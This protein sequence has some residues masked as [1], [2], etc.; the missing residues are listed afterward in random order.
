MRILLVITGLGVGGAERL[1]TALADHYG[2]LGHEVALAYFHGEVELEPSNDRVRL[3]NLQ[4]TRTPL[5]VISAAWRLR[6]LILE[7]R[8]DV[9]NTHLV[10]A[11]I[12]SRVL[13]LI[14]PIPKLVTSA[15]NTFEGGQLRMLGYRLTNCLANA[16][17]NVSQEAVEAFE[18][19]GAVPVG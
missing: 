8:P 18:R 2:S 13:R 1:V 11:N 19:S 6:K 9:V 15:H 14:T 12:L 17:T 16:S 3:V 5:G 4:M 10:H 7:F